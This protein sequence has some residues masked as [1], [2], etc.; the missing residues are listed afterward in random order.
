MNTIYTYIKYF[1]RKLTELIETN[2]DSIAR[3][4]EDVNSMQS[5]SYVTKATFAPKAPH[6]EGNVATVVD[7]F[8]FT[9][10]SPIVGDMSGMVCEIK[11]DGQ[12]QY[13]I[14]ATNTANTIILSQESLFDITTDC[15]VTIL[16]TTYVNFD[17]TRFPQIYG[18]YPTVNSGAVVVPVITEDMERLVIDLYI[19]SLSGDNKIVIIGQG[20]QG[21]FSNQFRWE[22]LENDKESTTLAGHFFTLNLHW[23]IISTS[24]ILRYLAG[25]YDNFLLENNTDWQYVPAANFTELKARRF[26]CREIDGVR[27]CEYNSLIPRYILLN[28]TAV[29]TKTG[30]AGEGEIRIMKYDSETGLTS[31]LQYES[32]TRFG[33]GEGVQTI[34]LSQPDE[35]KYGD[36]YTLQVRRSG[37]SV[38]LS[39]GSNIY[40]KEF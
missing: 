12:T 34:V 33:S 39:E 8:E 10:D 22:T 40:I 28:V 37:G 11:I 18:L 14:I 9:V 30:G 3:L 31:E 26:A 35:A 6:Y 24:G 16:D 27:W 38:T 20:S 23:D 13:S 32:T 36:R 17:K 21:F 4:T 1:V 15:S 7:N 19:E 5:R 2:T 29:L 25:Y